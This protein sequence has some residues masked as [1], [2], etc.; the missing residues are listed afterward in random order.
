[1]SFD[2]LL[3]SVFKLLK[4]RRCS[5]GKA[6][7][8]QQNKGTTSN[9]GAVPHFAEISRFTCFIGFCGNFVIYAYFQAENISSQTPKTFIDPCLY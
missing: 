4:L 8:K 3:R 9:L 2:D 5:D 6:S 1:M 7:G